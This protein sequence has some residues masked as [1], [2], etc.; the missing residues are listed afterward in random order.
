MKIKTNICV[1]T[2]IYLYNFKTY[3]EVETYN[4][5]IYMMISFELLEL[6]IMVSF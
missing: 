1:I 2:R 5:M 6:R 4:C 3:F